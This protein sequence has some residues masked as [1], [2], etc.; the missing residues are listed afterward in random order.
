MFDCGKGERP[1]RLVMRILL[2]RMRKM[3]SFFRHK[4]VSGLRRLIDMGTLFVFSGRVQIMVSMCAHLCEKLL[5]VL[6]I[7]F[8]ARVRY[9]FMRDERL[10]VF[11][12]EESGFTLFVAHKFEFYND[13]YQMRRRGRG[14]K[15]LCEAVLLTRLF[16]SCFI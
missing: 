14:E 10:V 1:A 13:K 15:T 6:L 11:R 3:V 2:R 16:L 7:F 12:L 4:R 5:I 9:S 8:I